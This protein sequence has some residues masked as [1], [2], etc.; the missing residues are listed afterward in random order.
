MKQR[1]L[2]PKHR[3]YRR[4]GGRGIKICER[5]MSFVNYIDDVIKEIGDCPDDMSLD[6]ID[7]DGNYEPGNIRWATPKQQTNNRNPGYK[8]LCPI[9]RCSNCGRFLGKDAFYKKQGSCKKCEKVKGYLWRL[10]HPDYNLRCV[11]EK[12][13]NKYDLTP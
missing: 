11:R 10:D 6:R 12:R 13:E 4:Y 8:S 2:N 5:W 7:N 9:K 3:K 1:C